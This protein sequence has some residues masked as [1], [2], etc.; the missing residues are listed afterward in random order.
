[1]A[2]F[3]RCLTSTTIRGCSNPKPSGEAIMS[4]PRSDPA[5][6]IRV[7]YP[8]ARN[9]PATSSCISCHVNRLIRSLMNSSDRARRSRVSSSVSSTSSSVSVA[10][11]GHLAGL[12][13]QD[14]LSG[15]RGQL[16][17]RGNRTQSIARRHAEIVS[18][19]LI[20]PSNGPY[21]RQLLKQ[22]GFVLR[23][24]FD[25]PNKVDP[26]TGIVTNDPIALFLLRS[27]NGI[28]AQHRSLSAIYCQ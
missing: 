2:V 17:Q 16:K 6:E 14:L 18:R 20:P 4:F 27:K 26:A 15:L 5:G 12:N 23:I 21:P 24:P 13:L 11:G 22:F 7:L 10:S 8:I 28:S 1:M 19:Y 9:R 3:G 25:D